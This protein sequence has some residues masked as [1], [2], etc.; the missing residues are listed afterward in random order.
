M[1]FRID[2]AGAVADAARLATLLADQ[3]PSATAD[4][5]P[6]TGTLRVNT[7]LRAPE[8]IVLLA[9]AGCAVAPQKVTLLPSVCCGGCSG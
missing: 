3:D 7:L 2:L 5:D 9:D 4:L 1:E 6:G 8:L